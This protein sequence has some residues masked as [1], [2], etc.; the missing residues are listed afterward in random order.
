[1]YSGDCSNRACFAK[2]VVEVLD[3][4]F[5]LAKHG[6]VARMDQNVAIWNLHAAVEFVGVTQ[7]DKSELGFSISV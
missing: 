1:M 2:L 6:E 4:H 3:H 7:E 5:T